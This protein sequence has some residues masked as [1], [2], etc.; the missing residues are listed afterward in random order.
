MTNSRKKNNIPKFK[1][2]ED[3]AR[4]WDTHDTTDFENEFK[5]VNARF[6]KNLSQGISIRLDAQTLKI[7]HAK[8]KAKGID[9]TTLARMW[10]LEHLQVL[11][12]KEKHQFQTP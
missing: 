11:K 6:A 4:F 10:I 8:A 3:E 1:N 12:H 2:K 5:P 7:L 9:S